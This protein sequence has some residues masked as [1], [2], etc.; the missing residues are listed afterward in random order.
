MEARNIHEHLNYTNW[1]GNLE[2]H[3]SL[4]LEAKEAIKGPLLSAIESHL[5]SLGLH[6]TTGP[7]TAENYHVNIVG[8]EGWEVDLVSL[9]YTRLDDFGIRWKKFGS[10]APRNSPHKKVHSVS[11][12]QLDQIF[13]Q[14]K[15]SIF[16]KRYNI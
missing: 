13:D 11:L 1:D 8:V 12:A 6:G 2:G 10:T 4:L 5:D 14:R 15:G 9:T 16:A 7:D 3:D